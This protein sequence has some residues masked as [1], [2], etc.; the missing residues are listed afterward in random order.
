MDC[1]SM[2]NNLAVVISILMIFMIFV[3]IIFS[4]EIQSCNFSGQGLPSLNLRILFF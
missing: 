1:H 2:I 3:I 4:I